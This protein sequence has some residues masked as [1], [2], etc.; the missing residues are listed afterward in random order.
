MAPDFPDI[1]ELRWLTEGVGVTL[2]AD[3]SAYPE[4]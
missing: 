4:S 3:V 2:E 1:F